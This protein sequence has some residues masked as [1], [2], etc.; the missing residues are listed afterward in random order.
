[1]SRGKELAKNTIIITIG[2]ISTQFISFILLPL[3]TTLLSTSEYGTVDILNTYVQ[4]LLP[5]VTLMIEQGA[6]RY[7]IDHFDDEENKGKIIS[8]SFC[9]LLVQC[10]LCGCIFL[11]VG[12]W[13]KNDY[14]YYLLAILIVA[15][16]SGWSLQL[17]RGFR[18]LSIY[19]AGSFLTAM[20]QIGF[21]IL[22]IAGLKMGA[23]GMLRATFLGNTACFLFVLVY[24]RI[25]KY[26]IP[27]VVE[28]N[29]IKDMLKYSVPL[30]PNQLSL[31]VI[32]SSDRTIVNLFLGT[33]ANGI[34]AVSHKFS[35]IYQTI[36]S[37]FQLSWHEIGTVHFQDED[38]D[39]FFS[40]T[41]A[42]VYRFFMAMC[43][44][45]IAFMPFVFPVLIKEAFA[46]AYYTIPIYLVAV[47][48]NIVVGLLGVVYVATKRT[49]E[50]A[51]STI[52][53][54]II[55]IVVHATLIKSMGLYAAAISTLIG[56]FTVMLYRMKDT[57]KYLNIKY[58][59]S[60][61]LLT[62]VMIGILLV[63]YYTNNLILRL[64][65]TV[66]ACAVA[67]LL[68]KKI[69]MSVIKEVIAGFKYK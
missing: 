31:W 14:K 57:K 38:R 1:M 36:Y 8:S 32:N 30:I 63:P 48:C 3:Y 58:K 17:A 51:K 46:S 41:F 43:L 7:L 12:H 29:T 9:V 6:F 11:V 24:L 2:K 62:V 28:K 26:I 15:S 68:N 19:A 42:D 69:L 39:E 50:I 27:S 44:G 21:N 49:A 34:L 54:G 60:D 65:G 47:L 56:Y 5:V 20:V 4:L 55:N 10:I 61:F 33:A 18:K 59:Y 45:L 53:A 13:I 52:Y 16:F 23:V 25:Y 22:F 66:L 64:G 37:M 40:E 35:T 67:L